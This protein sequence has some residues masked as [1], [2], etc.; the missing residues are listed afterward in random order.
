MLRDI[1]LRNLY[2]NYRSGSVL[3]T[4]TEDGSTEGGKAVCEMDDI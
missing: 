3:E 2:D 1:M 4:S